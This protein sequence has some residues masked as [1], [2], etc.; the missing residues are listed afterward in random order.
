MKD[1]ED[2]EKERK[3]FSLLRMRKNVMKK[4]VNY[5]MCNIKL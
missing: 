5:I 3:K 4:D 2:Q 1:E